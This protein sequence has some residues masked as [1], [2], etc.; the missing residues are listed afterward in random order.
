MKRLVCSNGSKI[1]DNK[2]G[3]QLYAKYLSAEAIDHVRGII[4][5]NTIMKEVF[6]HG[7]PYTDKNTFDNLTGYGVP[8]RFQDY[9]RSTR[10]P[11]DGIADFTEAHKTEIENINFVYGNREQGIELLNKLSGCDLYTLT[12][13]MP[14]NFEIGGA[15]VDKAAALQFVCDEF[16]ISQAEVMAIGDSANDLAMLH[17]AGVSVAMGDASYEIREAADFITLGA[18]ECGVALAINSAMGYK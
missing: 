3:S 18:E 17:F 4:R 5:D 13:S 7:A 6:W 8:E 11:V 12:S 14:F 2:S 15:G 10:T 16:G 1:Y 9:V